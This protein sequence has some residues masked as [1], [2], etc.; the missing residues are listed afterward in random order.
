MIEEPRVP[1]LL[2]AAALLALLAFAPVAAALPVDLAVRLSESERSDADKARD[3]GRQP[4]EV[5]AF[6]GITPG[7]AVMDVIAAGGYY[8]EVLSIA[9]GPKGRVYAQNTEFV[10][11]FR[12]GVND[13][14]MTARL[15]AGRLPNVERVDADLN[16]ISVADGSLDVAITALNFHDIYN[17]GGEQAAADFLAAIYKKLKPGGVLG[18]IDHGADSG[19][20]N[21]KL[22]RIEKQHVLDVI[23][24][25]DFS[26]EAESELLASDADD[27]SQGVFA[28]GIRGSTDRFLL[29]LRKPSS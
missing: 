6:L 8:T 14:A 22:H 4:A 27:H 26:L 5:V 13:K 28:P 29:R 25:S 16:A 12:D 9:V 19:F 3:A 23:E 20:D 15:A 1:V 17:S 11:K 2:P 18:I 7:M 24:K 21:A 10:L